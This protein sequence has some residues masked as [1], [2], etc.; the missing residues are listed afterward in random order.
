M[1]FSMLLKSYP[2]IHQLKPPILRSRTRI[3]ELK[4]CHPQATHPLDP[5]FGSEVDALV[6]R[7][8]QAHEALMTGDVDTYRDPSDGGTSP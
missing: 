5:R 3:A 2:L 4:S 8:A 6:V 1:L 7:A